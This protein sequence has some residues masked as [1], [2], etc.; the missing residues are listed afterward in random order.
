[1]AQNRTAQLTVQLIDE[2]SRP[3]R[4][5]ESALKAA[6]AEVKSIAAAMQE[7]GAS[8]KLVASLSRLKLS[9]SDVES[10]ARAFKEYSA[11]AGLAANAADWTKTQANDVTRWEGNTVRALRSVISERNAESRALRNQAAAELELRDAQEKQIRAAGTSRHG[12]SARGS[13]LGQ[14]LPL[15]GPAVVAA[16]VKGVEAA[17]K[18]QGQDLRNLSAGIPGPERNAAERQAIALSAKYPNLGTA[19]VLQTYREL[20]S[21]LPDSAEVPKMMDVVV[22]AKAAMEASGL[23]GSGLVYALK[24]AELLGKAKSPADLKDYLNSFVKAQQVEGATID[25]E[26]MFNFAQQLKAAAPN[27]SSRFVNTLGPLLL[28][29]LGANGGTAVQQFEKQIQGGFQ[30]NLHAAAK[31]FVAIG[32][33]S[34]DDFELTKTGEIKGMKHGHSVVGADIAEH[35]PDKWVYDVLTPALVKAGYKTTEDQIKELPR[36][37]PNTNAANVVAKLLQQKDQWAAKAERIDA[38]QGTE[39]LPDQM[40]GVGVAFE[41][42]KTQLVDFIGVLDLPALKDIGAGLSFMAQE[43]GSAKVQIDAFAQSFPTAA[44]AVA[45]FGLAAAAAGGG[46]LSMK[47][48]TGFGLTGSA[49]A[50]SGSAAELSAAAV[51]LGGK[52]VLPATA[53]AAGAAGWTTMGEI[54]GAVPVLAAAALPIMLTPKPMAD[55]IGM[56]EAAPGQAFEIR[57][58]APPARVGGIGSD[59]VAAPTVDTSEIDKA[60]AK[61]DSLSVSPSV[62]VRVNTSGIDDAQ[63]KANRLEETLRRIGQMSFGPGATV[64]GMPPSLGS[65]MRGDFSSSGIHGE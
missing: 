16:V 28:Q 23:D 62:D 37:F 48:F 35:D 60:A 45:D 3:A 65:K 19:E 29:E 52:G 9:A 34:K 58:P 50:L 12:L 63:G 59:A 31:E 36:L 43:L 4:S 61:L 14:V 22:K 10:V 6:E 8:D 21:V 25:P 44:R 39:S 57:R 33:A 53:G 20:R 2:C 40:Q 49:T 27:L 54:A 55:A 26:G 30:G 42:F 11:S 51:A 17:T 18:I 56:N 64:G 15:L 32:L 5:V 47:M 41:A 7:S 1:M 38:A 13:E 24:A 46:W